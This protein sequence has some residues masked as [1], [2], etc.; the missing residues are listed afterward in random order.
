MSKRSKSS[1]SQGKF[2]PIKH[3]PSNSDISSFT[4]SK[5]VKLKS[6]ESRNNNE[7]RGSD[8]SISSASSPSESMSSSEITRSHKEDA[9]RNRIKM[10][11]SIV[12]LTENLIRTAQPDS[13]QK[14]E[15]IPVVVKGTL[16]QP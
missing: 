11:E 1:R 4:N 2:S 5:L 13:P 9:N 6:P 16:P 8:P 3:S 15:D 12:K 14:D 7:K 10:R